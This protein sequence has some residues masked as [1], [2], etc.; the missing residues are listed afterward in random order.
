LHDQHHKKDQKGHQAMT[1]ASLY[2]HAGI[3][4]FSYSMH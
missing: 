3:G 2:Q 1:F 4:R